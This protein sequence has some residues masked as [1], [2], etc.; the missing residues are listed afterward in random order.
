MARADLVGGPSGL[1]SYVGLPLLKANTSNP[2]ELQ[3]LINEYII[4]NKRPVN[5]S[6]V[7]INRGPELKLSHHCGVS[8]FKELG[9]A[10]STSA[11]RD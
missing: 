1:D 9:T 5:R 6:L 11:N 3:D 8:R 10:S 7:P 2:Q 4:Q